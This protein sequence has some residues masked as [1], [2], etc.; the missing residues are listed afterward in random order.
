MH[1]R[2]TLAF[3]WLGGR[4]SVRL[5]WLLA[6]AVVTG[7][8]LARIVPEMSHWQD[9]VL[10]YIGVAVVIAGAIALLLMHE[11]AHDWMARRLGMRISPSR[12]YPFGGVSEGYGDPGTPRSELLIALAGPLANL[13]AALLFGGLWLLLLAGD[14]HRTVIGLLALT[15]AVIG[16]AN[17]LPGLPLDGGRI[18][19]ALVWYLHQ[20]YT[21]GTR[22]AVFYGQVIS[23]FTLAAGVIALGSHTGWQPLGAWIILLSWAL[24]RTGR[25]ELLRSELV[26]RGARVSVGDVVVGLNARIHPE[27]TL[28][29]VLDVL[30]AHGQLGPA[31]VS[32]DGRVTGILSLDQ[33]RHWPRAVWPS[34]T[35][36][37]AMIPLA[38]VATIGADDSVRELLDRL[39]DGQVEVL[40]VVRQGEV[41]GAVDRRLAARQLFERS[42]AE[43]QDEAK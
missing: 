24:N 7:F 21:S 23:T 12:L 36:A 43:T 6:V 4:V 20:D 16:A 9:R 13:L 34:H 30:L 41:L 39:V 10:W 2:D 29:D 35:V 26:S 28:E 5:T 1:T 32:D 14:L 3:Q 40:A 38:R 33:L 42:R 25:E 37:E 15:S 31:L 27:Q 8:T 18:L 22:A 17:L 19:R 11:A